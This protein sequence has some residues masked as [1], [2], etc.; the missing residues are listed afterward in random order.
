MKYILIIVTL[1]AAGVVGYAIFGK[2][3]IAENTT[4]TPVV[5][6]TEENGGR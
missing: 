1:F 3:E 6:N 4:P 5:I 2:Q